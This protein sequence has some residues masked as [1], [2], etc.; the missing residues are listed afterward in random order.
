MHTKIYP[1]FENDFA[2]LNNRFA[3][4]NNRFAVI[5]N[6]SVALKLSNP[7]TTN[8]VWAVWAGDIT[9]WWGSRSL[10]DN[11]LICTLASVL[12]IFN[13]VYLLQMGERTLQKEFPSFPRYNYFDRIYW[14]YT[15]SSDPFWLIL[16]GS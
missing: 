12:N 2:A 4:L 3:A 11:S 7:K 13:S 9:I 6:R 1:D 14:G 10:M 8:K 5:N 15:Y 16:P